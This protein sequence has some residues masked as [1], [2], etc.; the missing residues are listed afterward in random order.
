MNVNLLSRWL[1]TSRLSN[2]FTHF[3]GWQEEGYPEDPSDLQQEYQELF[4]GVHADIYIPLWASTCKYEQGSLLDETTL[5]VLRFYRHWGYTPVAM[6]GN[7][8]DYIGQQLRFAA[9]LLA[10]ALHDAENAKDYID[11]LDEFIALYLLDTVRT[12]A[13]GIKAHSDTPLFLRVAEHLVNFCRDCSPAALCTPEDCKEH[14]LCW[15]AYENGRNAAISAGPIHTIKTAGR[16]NCGGKC[17]VHATE[18][19]G[20]ILAVETG[21]DIGDPSIRACVRGRGYRRTYMT[22]Q[23]LRYPMKRIGKRGE[24]RFTRISWEEAADLITAEWVRIRDKYGVGARYVNYGTG[25][26]AVIRPDRLT[27]RLLNLDGGYVDLFGSY[28]SACA[29]Y[30]TP[31]IYG[32]NMSG[33]SVE[34]LLNTKLLILWAHNPTETIFSPQLSYMIVQA[35]KKGAKV[36]VIDPRNSDSALSFADQWIP[37]VPSTDGALANAMAYVIWEE[38]LQDQSFMDRFCLGFDEAHMPEGS[39]KSQNFKNYIFGGID[40]IA[41]TPEWAE[42]ITGIPADVIRALAREYATT[43]PACILPGLGAQRIGNG[44]QTVRAIAALTA[45]TGNIG[46]PG[47]GAAGVGMSKEEAQP[48]FP[49]GDRPYKATISVFMWLE[50]IERG[51]QMTR[52]KD[53]IQ[54]VEQLDTDIKMLFNL[55]GNTLINQHSDINHT[56][57]VLQDESKCEFIL[58]TD[59]FM[60]PSAKFADILLPG[61]SFLE[62]DNMAGPWRQGHYLLHHNRVIEPIFGCRDEYHWISDV[63]HRLGLWEAWSEGRETREQWLEDIYNGLRKQEPELPPYAAFKANGG[64]TYKNPK[65]YIAYADQIRDPEH[66][67][68][69]TPSGKIEIYSQ[70]LADFENPAEIPALPIY[71]PCPEG[72]HD[73]LREKYPLQLIGWHTKRRCHSVHD[74]NPWMEETDPQR[75]W[76]HPDDA[77]ARGLRTGDLAEVWNDRGHIRMPVLVTDRIVR[78]VV[79]IAQGAWYNPDKDGTDKRGSI[80]VLTDRRPTPL[81]KGNPQHTNLVEVKAL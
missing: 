40:G 7:P 28:S 25:I 24:G 11:A 13:D 46:I 3:A 39:D 12:V 48:G 1:H 71:V 18:Q 61:T 22:G 67:P 16:N 50:A 75:M 2:F 5:E 49:I 66:H 21:C 29:Q 14:L 57:E 68:F 9:Y 76:I 69:K 43:K 80:N 33:N 34:D 77:A 53:H 27:K 23:R 37:I 10:C 54:G 52:K 31:Y 19:D 64:Y 47:G 4:M 41:K 72:P 79:A 45:L 65:T 63:A 35:R 8:P 78:G 74:N 36:I 55:A 81:A 59:V 30:V 6:D 60:T 70:R 62:E 58:C 44:E 32:D 15:E 20:C 17:A 38:G 73:P 56:I 42:P 26:S 51:A